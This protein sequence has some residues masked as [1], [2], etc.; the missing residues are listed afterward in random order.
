[1]FINSKLVFI[2][3]AITLLCQ[4]V[5]CQNPSRAKT[6]L[7][8]VDQALFDAAY[9]GDDKLA[10]EALAAGADPN[11]KNDTGYTPLIFAADAN[12]EEIIKLLIKANANVNAQDDSGRTSLMVAAI[13]ESN[14]AIKLLLNAQANVNLAD[15]SG[16][17]ALMYAISTGNASGVKCF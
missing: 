10:K 17:T 11:A 14:K 5:F 15:R 12:Q 2:F 7:R 9:L 13:N 6:P 4:V 3:L 8:L 1:M 16:K